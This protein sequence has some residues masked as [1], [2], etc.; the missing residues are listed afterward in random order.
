MKQIE[1]FP[2]YLISFC[3]KVFSNKSNKWL[4]QCKNGEGYLCVSLC[5]DK[6]NIIGIYIVC[7]PRPIFK[8]LEAV[9]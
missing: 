6:K 8:K 3:G 2:E 4:K 7:L 1:E 9:I 5:K